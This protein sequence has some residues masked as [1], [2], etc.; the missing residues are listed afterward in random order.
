M[1]TRTIGTRRCSDCEQGLSLLRHAPS[2]PWRR[3]A[4][5]IILA[6]PGRDD[7]DQLSGTAAV[8]WGILATPSSLEQLVRTLAD[9]YSIPPER[10]SKDVDALVADLI[11]R[12]AIELQE[13][14]G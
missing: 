8:I 11:G 1:L 9:L 3:V 2:I 10:I 5:D 13:T 4:D 7:F 14:H 6:P 12:G